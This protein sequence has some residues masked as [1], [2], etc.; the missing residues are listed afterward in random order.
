[1]KHFT[2]RILPFFP[3]VGLLSFVVLFSLAATM[4]PG[5]SFNLPFE[6][7]FSFFHN[8]LCDLMNPITQGG[9]VNEARLMAISAH[10]VLSLAMLSF[11]AVLPKI[12]PHQ[13]RNTKLVGWFGMTTMGVFTFMF[14][15]FHDLV[16]VLTAVFGTVTLVPFFIEMNSHHNKRLRWMAYFCYALGVVVFISYVSKLG[17]YF[18]PFLQKMTFIVDALWVFWTCAIVLRKNGEKV[19]PIPAG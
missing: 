6:E 16:V 15:D 14:T 9:W 5:G 10:I 8:F 17:Y 2:T 19:I 18:L 3:M 4:Y 13:N 11:F 7:G 1:M 12:F